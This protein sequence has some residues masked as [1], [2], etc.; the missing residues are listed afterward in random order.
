MPTAV[1]PEGTMIHKPAAKSTQSRWQK[2]IFKEINEPAPQLFLGALL[3]LSLFMAESWVLGN[4]PDSSNDALYAVLTAVFAIFIVE[5]VV[6]CVVQEGYF[7]GFFFWMD[8]LGTLSI[9][10]DIGWIADAFIPTGSVSGTG[11]VLRATRAAKLG[12]R[13]GRLLRL[14]KLMRFTR[15]LPCFGSAGG[16]G[17][18]EPTMSAI[19]RVSEELQAVLSLRTAALVM[20]LVIVVPFMSYE[21][22][23]FSPNAWV[24][25]IKLQA[26]NQ[27]ATYYE[28][29]NLARKCNNFYSPKDDQLLYLSVESPYIEG[30]YFEDSY[31]TRD[32]LR[33]NNIVKFESSYHVSNA[34]L[35]AQV[36][37][38]PNVQT[39][40]DSLTSFSD[41]YEFEVKLEIDITY[42]RQQNSMF[43]ILIILLVIFVLFSFTASF[44][45]A[46]NR[47][48]VLPLEKMM[49]TLRNSAMMMIKSMQSVESANAEKEAEEGR[50]LR[51]VDEEGNEIDDD[52][53]ED[54]ELET[55]MLEKM[56]EK[57]ARIV[58]HVLPNNN[59]MNIANDENIDSN[60]QTW[61]KQS[62]TM[63]MSAVSK[64]RTLGFEE[65]EEAEK[66][67]LKEL[68]EAL[69]VVS[70]EQLASWD[71]D[72]LAFSSEELID[73]I[74][75]IFS[76]LNLLKEF[77][78]PRATFQAFLKEVSSRYLDNTYHNFKHGCDVCHTSYR[79]MVV[80]QLTQVFSSLEV[81]SVLVGAL[82]HDVGHPGINNLFLVKS[83]HE[84]ALMH[85]DRSPLENMHCVMLY[86]ILSKE[87]TNIFVNL[88]EEQWR[89]SR[90]II[91]TIILGTDMSHHFEQI[92]KTQLFLEV[93]G[94]D[95]KGFCTGEKDS[96]D[97]LREEKNR[98]F[99]MELVLHCSDISNPFKPFALCAKW[100]DLVVEE[101]CRQGDKEK[102]LGMTVSPMCDRDAVNLCNMQ[103]GF[104]EFVVAPLII[105]FVSILPPLHEIGGHMLTNYLTWGSKRQ[106]ELTA[107]SC[108]EGDQKQGSGSSEESKKLTERMHKFKDKMGFL[109]DMREL[110]QRK[111]PSQMSS[112]LK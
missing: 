74:T 61:L 65:D 105:A 9:I 112:S 53:E 46:V 62:Y 40:F 102:E 82:A 106:D 7:N 97:C 33:D 58:K 86:E 16:E 3:M 98:L 96:I 77:N 85:N 24:D 15:Y 71:F 48:V 5:I 28:I 81:L 75:Y 42:R 39:F 8:T 47:L 99:I 10:L 59:E 100:A 52:E 4:A 29:S 108:V 55:V 79:L 104:I 32:V 56:V 35:S 70:K 91:L 45:N 64:V 110:N 50:K 80:P 44:S 78:I 87:Q 34:T 107:Q 37:S 84:L 19:K 103:M 73:V 21:V 13:Y 1:I 11:S 43:G 67:R 57:L 20:L 22:T 23:D 93:N 18:A 6:L 49:T 30:N 83:K 2:R 38:N 101:F 95:T 12:A 31:D 90:K 111:R 36:D 69:T 88:P 60:T 89:E 27:T 68:D 72:V 109:R 54:E 17:E 25:Q 26:K 92:S 63:G 14:L 94:D 41:T 76:L 66:I 51:T